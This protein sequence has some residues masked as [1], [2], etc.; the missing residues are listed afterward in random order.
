MPE[1]PLEERK[2]SKCGKFSWDSEVDSYNERHSVGGGKTEPCDTLGD[3]YI[4]G[5]KQQGE[6]AS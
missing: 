1:G 5:V 4:N 2:C 6:G 3:V